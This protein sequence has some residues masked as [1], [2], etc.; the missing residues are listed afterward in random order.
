MDAKFSVTVAFSLTVSTEIDV[1]QFSDKSPSFW[2]ERF[3][4]L[5]V[6]CVS[7]DAKAFILFYFQFG[8]LV[9]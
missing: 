3:I 6:Q 1:F 8:Q 2:P 9:V 4:W 7:R 5:L